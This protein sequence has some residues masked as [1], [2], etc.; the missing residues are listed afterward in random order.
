MFSL[1]LVLI[2]KTFMIDPRFACKYKWEII[3]CERSLNILCSAEEVR[4]NTKTQTF[5]DFLVIKK[6]AKML[7]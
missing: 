1:Y 6:P 4:F 2:F 5:L 3:Y 7:R